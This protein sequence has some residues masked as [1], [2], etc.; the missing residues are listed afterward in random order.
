MKLCDEKVHVF[1]HIQSGGGV[2]ITEEERGVL[3]TLQVVTFIAL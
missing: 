1:L 2:R 3:E